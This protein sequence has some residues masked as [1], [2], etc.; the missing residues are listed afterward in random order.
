MLTLPRHATINVQQLNAAPSGRSI[1]LSLTHWTSEIE[2]TRDSVIFNEVDAILFDNGSVA[3]FNPTSKK[4][5]FFRN[6]IEAQ[7]EVT[8]TLLG[9]KKSFHH[10][11]YKGYRC[12][13]ISSVLSQQPECVQDWFRAE[14]HHLVSPLE[15]IYSFCFYSDNCEPQ[16]SSHT[17]YAEARQQF[18]LAVDYDLDPSEAL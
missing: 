1:K 11:S 7:V 12:E 10:L 13:I 5:E 17:S 6:A 3:W 4:T 14:D 9:L 16:W 18:V 8:L 2:T 15:Y